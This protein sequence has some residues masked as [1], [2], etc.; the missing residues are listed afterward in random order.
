MTGA[1]G[2]TGRAVATALARKGHHVTGLSRRPATLEG[3]RMVVGDAGDPISMAPIVHASDA[4]VHVAGILLG[5]RLAAVPGIER[6]G[7]LVAVSSAGVHS[8]HR[9]SAAAYRA[10][11]TAIATACTQARI[12]RPT[13]IYGSMRDRNIHHL[14]LFARRFGFLP[15]IGDAQALVQPIHFADLADVIVELL[16]SPPLSGPVEVGGAAALT[17]RDALLAILQATSRGTR[18][19]TFPRRAAVGLAAILDALRGS[20]WVERIERLSEDRSVDNT[21]VIAATGVRP[22]PFEVGV[23]QQAHEMAQES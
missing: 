21:D 15:L 17:L 23:A 13:M 7:R 10:G 22:R 11:E 1:S 3:V 20:R 16:D 18:L 6:L 4:L 12:V 5:E 2:L 19:V 8:R 9:T 14:I